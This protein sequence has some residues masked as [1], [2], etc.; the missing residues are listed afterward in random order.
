VIQAVPKAENHTK[1]VWTSPVLQNPFKMEVYVMEDGNGTSD[2]SFAEE[3]V[4]QQG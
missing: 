4:W 2:L 3:E 1:A